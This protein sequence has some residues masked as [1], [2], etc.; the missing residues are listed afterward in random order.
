MEP[1][2]MKMML[3]FDGGLPSLNDFLGRVVTRKWMNLRILSELTLADSPLLCTRLGYHAILGG[4]LGFPL[5]V[6]LCPHLLW[7]EGQ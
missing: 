1:V 2:P 7:L 6:Q 3:D 5:L 4:Q